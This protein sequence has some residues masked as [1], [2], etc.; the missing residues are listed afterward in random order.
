MIIFIRKE[1]KPSIVEII[2]IKLLSQILM[3][4]I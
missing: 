2:Q 1:L 4:S 3:I